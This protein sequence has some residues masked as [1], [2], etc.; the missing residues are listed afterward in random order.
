MNMD[1]IN[2]SIHIILCMHMYA[3]VYVCVC[4]VSWVKSKH[5]FENK[6]QNKSIDKE[7]R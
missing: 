7:K 1:L 3:Y 6:E 5:V 4:V 2:V